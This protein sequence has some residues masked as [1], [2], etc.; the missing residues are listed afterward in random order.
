MATVIGRRTAR[1]LVAVAILQGFWPLSAHAQRV[2]EY[3][4]KAAFLQNFAKFV[5][6]P[7]TVEG[8]EFHLCILGDD[9]FGHWIDEATSGTRVKNRPVVVRRIRQVEEA[10]GCQTVFISAS[11]NTRVRVVLD[12]LRPAAVLTVSDVPQFVDRGGMIGFTTTAGRIRFIAN[13]AVAR[14]AGLQLAS[15]LLRVAASVVGQATP[16]E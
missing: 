15:E 1:A 13:P 16:K 5:E 11:E 7:A 2:S 4:V 6:W 9:P 3:Q 8:G 12:G 14:A 10:A